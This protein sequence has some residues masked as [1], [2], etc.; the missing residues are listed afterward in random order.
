MVIGFTLSHL[1]P[2]VNWIKYDKHTLTK[3]TDFDKL[4]ALNRPARS[5][6]VCRA[7]LYLVEDYRP[8]Y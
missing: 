4:K 6:D 2:R 8:S 3:P 7:F 5:K 1:N